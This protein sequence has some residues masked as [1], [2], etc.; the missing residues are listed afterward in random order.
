M[1]HL[2]DTWLQ[3]YNLQRQKDKR[4]EKVFIASLKFCKSAALKIQFRKS[5]AFV[6]L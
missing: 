2:N 1:M 6:D 5:A 3:H 4:K